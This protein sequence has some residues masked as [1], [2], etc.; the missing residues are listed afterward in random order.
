MNQVEFAAY[1]GVSK[2]YISSLINRGA[3]TGA[4]TFDGQGYDI[5]A[6]KAKAIII[7]NM[8]PS[9]ARGRKPPG[10]PPGPKKPD[11]PKKKPQ[12]KPKAVKPKKKSAKPKKPKK[13]GTPAP[14]LEPKSQ[15][16]HE[17]KEQV[18]E[19][20]GIVREM[21]FGR[22][23]TLHEQY[24]AALKKLEFDKLKGLVIDGPETYRRRFEIA[25]QIRD[26]CLSI[27]DR[28][29]PVVAAES[30]QHKCREIL[31]TEIR[32]IIDGIRQEISGL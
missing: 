32:Y 11:K 10:R 15:P 30:D 20:A 2:Q 14:K 12:P 22:A 13:T 25:R 7:A 19:S 17:E 24:K 1:M 29:A 6:A 8:D 23:R 4:Y 21:D 5:D 27:A 3:L 31:L 9:R 26:Q 18:V 28:C 16:T